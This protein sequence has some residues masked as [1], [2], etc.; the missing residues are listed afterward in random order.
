MFGFTSL[1]F[2]TETM[3][4]SFGRKSFRP[5]KKWTTS[6]CLAAIGAL[7]LFSWIPTA[8]WRSPNRCLGSIIWFTAN[9]HVIAIGIIAAILFFN[10]LVGVTVVIRL[11]R[12]PSVGECERVAASRICY[13]I[14]FT[15]IHYVS[16][17]VIF[18]I[19]ILQS[20]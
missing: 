18:I 6:V 20:C 17:V 12:V 15:V 11:M 7:M 13:Y 19:S 16:H 1:V 9:F 3:I 2:G 5:R 14:C 10:I 8:V 4:R